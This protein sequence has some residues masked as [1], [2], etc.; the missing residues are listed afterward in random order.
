MLISA[1]FP[2]AY[3]KAQDLQGRTV[4]VIIADCRMEDL[5]G[6]EKPVLYFQGKDRGLVLNKTN[7][8]VLVDAYGDETSQWNGR[9][10]ELFAARVSFQ[11]R[12]V[13]GLRVRVPAAPLHQP[14]PAQ[15]AQQPAMQPNQAASMAAQ[16][17]A[18]APADQPFYDDIPW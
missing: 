6:E 13:D 7:A 14:A 12:M 2:G 18:Q 16:A 15:P 5:G 4:S 11:G 3:L 8:G 1:A 10:L 9:P 17:P